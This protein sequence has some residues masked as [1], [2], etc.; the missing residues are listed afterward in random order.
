[1]PDE[2]RSWAI[3]SKVS[4]RKHSAISF[5]FL[6]RRNRDDD[7][8]HCSHLLKPVWFSFTLVRTF[9]CH[10][11]TVLIPLWDTFAQQWRSRME[12]LITTL[13]TPGILCSTTPETSSGVQQRLG[14]S[15]VILTDR[16][17]R[18]R[19]S[20][21]SGSSGWALNSDYES[22]LNCIIMLR[23]DRRT[24]FYFFK[25]V[26]ICLF[27]WTLFFPFWTH[28][29]LLCWCLLPRMSLMKFT[30]AWQVSRLEVARYF[31]SKLGFLKLY[32][33]REVFYWEAMA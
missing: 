27:N 18:F 28:D 11:L 6:R 25:T 2:K 29:L 31:I 8:V 20:L 22:F 7:D 13:W 19:F 15:N 26:A 23:N 1:M 33:I 12:S 32:A 16:Y 5:F 9:R 4:S 17:L 24:F 30:Y 10:K 14:K 21:S 3:R